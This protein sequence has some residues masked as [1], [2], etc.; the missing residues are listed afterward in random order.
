MASNY[1][2]YND[3]DGTVCCSRKNCRVCNT[4][5]LRRTLQFSPLPLS[6]PY[7]F[8][9]LLHQGWYWGPLSRERATNMLK[10]EAN[11]TFLV[12]DS[13]DH[14]HLY[15]ISFVS[16]GQVIHTLIKHRNGKWS[17]YK[18]MKRCQPSV[19]Q[20]VQQSMKEMQSLLWDQGAQCLTRPLT[21]FDR[22]QSLQ[23]ICRFVIRLHTRLD[24]IPSL[25]LPANMR[26]YL[27]GSV[28]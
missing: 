26:S 13:S 21:R 27:Q 10:Q 12:R 14:F 9:D 16:R 7:N 6:N 8:N 23:H 2:L 24:L 15:A 25:P 28:L 11:G 18:N 17:F 19:V 1:F 4:N 22:V 20:L 5:T 3:V